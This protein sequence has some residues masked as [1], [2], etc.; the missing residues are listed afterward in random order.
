MHHATTPKAVL[1]PFPPIPARAVAMALLLS[2]P[3]GAASIRSDGLLAVDGQALFPVGLVEL[4]SARYADWED[5][6]RDSG[7]NIVWDIE[8]AYAD[9][10]PGCSEVMRASR[11]GGW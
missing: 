8:I 4:G 7:A 3:A 1:R 5:R 10:T 6:I 11:D 9:T 2:S